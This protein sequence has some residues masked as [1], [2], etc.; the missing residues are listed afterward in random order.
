MLKSWPR[1]LWSLRTDSRLVVTTMNIQAYDLSET[2][3][4]DD[5]EDGSVKEDLGA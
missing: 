2:M 5:F 3:D 4:S 1:I